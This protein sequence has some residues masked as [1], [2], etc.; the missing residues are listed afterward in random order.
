[1]SKEAKEKTK[2]IEG[3]IETLR[4]D[5][6]LKKS[7]VDLDKRLYDVGQELFRLMDFLEE[8]KQ[9]PREERDLLIN[10]LKWYESQ[11]NRPAFNFMISEFVDSY[12]NRNTPPLVKEKECEHKNSHIL[13]IES[14]KL[15]ECLDCGGV[16]TPIKEPED[17]EKTICWACK[18][19]MKS[20]G[21]SEGLCNEC[22]IKG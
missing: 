20:N 17:K 9:Q 11:P 18:E 14:S 8:Y 13:S 1:M 16:R 12:V 21:K 5:W 3:L 22:Q 15:E 19:E 2:H 6:A 7:D 10:F 4:I